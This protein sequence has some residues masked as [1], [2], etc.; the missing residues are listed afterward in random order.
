MANC[1]FSELIH[2]KLNQGQ[3]TKFYRGNVL[4]IQHKDKT[5]ILNITHMYTQN[6]N[7]WKP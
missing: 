6:F 7:I 3:R 1:F 5:I 2:V 4:K